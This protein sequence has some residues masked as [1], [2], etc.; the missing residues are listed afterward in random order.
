MNFYNLNED[1]ERL[2]FADAVCQGYGKNRG[3]FFPASIPRLAD[4]DKLL[5]MPLVQRSVEVLHP[6]VGDDLDKDQLSAIVRQAFDFPVPLVQV[7]EHCYVLEL[8]HGPTLAFK[9]F[10][11]RFLALCL[12]AFQAGKKTTILTATSGDTGAAVAHAFYGL[13]NIR[14]VVLYPK[15]KISRYQEKLFTT[16]GG[17]IETV[18]VE[19]NF[20]DCQALV[21]QAFEDPSVTQNLNLNSANSINVSRLIAQVCYYFEA[22]SQLSPRHR[23]QV[24]LSVPSGNFGNLTAAL[25]AKAMGLPIKRF[26]AAT[27]AND[28]VPR[29]L[30]TGRWD[31]QA[32]VATASNAMDVSNPN[33]WPRIEEML[34]TRIINPAD[35]SGH[36]VSESETR[37]AIKYLHEHG[38]LGEPHGAVAWRALQS[39]LQSGEVGL[40]LGTAHPAKFGQ[41][42]EKVIG[43]AIDLP[44]ALKNSANKETLSTTIRGDYAQLRNILLAEGKGH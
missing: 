37:E 24:V 30:Q 43:E 32:T 10:G 7:D 26:I 18:A 35:L 9:D 40:F 39:T 22:F 6:W 13:E 25:F 8:F 27:N 1:K 14:V 3:L 21:K 38:Y 28:T 36:A 31:V 33:N 29:Y 4:I 17:N 23:N 2:G 11:A 20:D 19:G 5:E 15:G 44:D 34:A 41:V 12:Q 16:L 42:V